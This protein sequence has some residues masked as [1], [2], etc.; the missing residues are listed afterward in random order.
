MILPT[1]HLREEKSLIRI[2]ADILAILNE[3][4]T[5]SR[6]WSE[7]H[8]SQYEPRKISG[9]TYNW[10]VL[11]LDLLFMIGAIEYDSGRISMAKR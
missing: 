11:S 10:F 6:I 1:K 9:I 5:I 7:L 8:H 2:G 3:P 4:K